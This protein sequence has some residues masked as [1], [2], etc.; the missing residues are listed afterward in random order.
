MVRDGS[1][2]ITASGG[3]VLGSVN[4]PINNADY[5]SFILQADSSGADV[6]AFATD[7]G[8]NV[9]LIKQSSE[10]GL[11]QNGRTFA[12]LLTTTNDVEASGLS[13][14]QGLIITQPFYWNLNDATRA[15]SARFSAR[16]QDQS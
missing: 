11:K 2:V 12:A 8:D 3:V 10:F 6:I 15:W 5:A 1:S 9:N 4:V 14:G 16:Q 7:G 13:V